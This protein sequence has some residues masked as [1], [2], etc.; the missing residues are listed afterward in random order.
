MVSETSLRAYRIISSTGRL[1]RLRLRVFKYV[2]EHPGDT[3]LDAQYFL[4]IQTQSI[5]GRYSELV[6]M[7]LIEIVGKVEQENY[8]RNTYAPTGRTIPLKMKK[9]K[10]YVLSPE[11]HLKIYRDS[12]LK[13]GFFAD[14]YEKE[15]IERLAI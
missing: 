2:C 11:E 9:K 14:K 7:D 1:G 4:S 8:P 10:K 5:T 15:L 13:N 3:A 6:A 12:I